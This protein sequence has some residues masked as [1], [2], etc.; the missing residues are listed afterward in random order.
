M[1]IPL[2]D[3][4]PRRTYPV[5]NT[6]LIL[7]NVIVFLFQLTL[8][9]AQYKV[10]LMANA[11]IPSHVNGFLGGHVSFEAAFLPVI[12]SMFLHMGLLHIAGNMLFL[13]IFG[14][15]VEDYFGHFP[16]LLFYFVCGVGSD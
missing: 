1:F 13:W 6:L 11:T 5:V 16:Y 3:L 2:K 9:P 10:F 4:N 14:D 15:N 8:T 7:T 12:T